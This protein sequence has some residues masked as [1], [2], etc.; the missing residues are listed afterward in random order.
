ML[1]VRP[2][3]LRSGATYRF[4]LSVT[5]TGIVNPGFAA[6]TVVANRPPY[7]GALEITTVGEQHADGWA[8]L[9]ELEERDRVCKENCQSSQC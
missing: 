6:V 8:P 3:T 9:V 5:F 1:I 7:G 4:E 2:D